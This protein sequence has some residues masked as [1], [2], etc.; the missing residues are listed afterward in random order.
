VS[1][2]TLV[3][4]GFLTLPKLVDK[5]SREPARIIGLDRGVIGAGLPADFMIFD[6]ETPFTVDG[7]RFASKGRNTCFEGMSLRG[8]VLYA[9]C[10]GAVCYDYEK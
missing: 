8:N 2:S 3:V 6:G 10:G 7:S 4:P 5:M 9:I 1:Y